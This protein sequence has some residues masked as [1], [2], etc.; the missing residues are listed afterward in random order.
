MSAPV[1]SLDMLGR[2]FD[3]WWALYRRTF[4]GNVVSSFF[5]PLFNALAMGVL[6]G[7]YVKVDPARLEGATSYLAFVVPGLLAGNAMMTGFGDASYPVVGALKWD[8]TYYAMQASPLRVRDIVNGHL[9]LMAFR[10]LVAS[11]VFVLVLAPFGVFA[12]WWGALGAVGVGVF[13]GLAFALPMYALSARLGEET[14]F[15]LL[16]RVGVMP[17]FLFSGA[18]FPLSNLSA[19][20]SAL[21]K[22][23]PLWHGVDLARMLCLDTWDGPQALLHIGYLGALSVVFYLVSVRELERRLQH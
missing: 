3:F 17:L 19:P 15:T 1:S 5:F 22:L 18:F 10:F 11:S 13:V 20:L 16:W 4:R 9:G 21:A 6:L 8:R 7:G 23:M 2:Q 12:T 14:W